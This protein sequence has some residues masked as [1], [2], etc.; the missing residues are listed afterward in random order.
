MTLSLA[1]SG[2]CPTTSGSSTQPSRR[3]TVGG[4]Q[5]D[6]GKE[7]G[8]AAL[9]SNQETVVLFMFAI[10]LG[11]KLLHVDTKEDELNLYF[12]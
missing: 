1:M 5:E 4:S 9:P 10:I 3:R 12:V 11:A 7:E 2:V 6:G 8:E